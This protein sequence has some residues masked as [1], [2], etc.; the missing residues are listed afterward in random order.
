MGIEI[1][2]TNVILNSRMD[3]TRPEQAVREFSKSLR[4]LGTCKAENVVRIWINIKQTN[5]NSFISPKFLT[6]I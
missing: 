4:Q 6:K 1:F 2:L 3:W 5:K